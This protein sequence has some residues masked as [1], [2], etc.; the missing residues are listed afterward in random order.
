MDST[1]TLQKNEKVTDKIDDMTDETEDTE[2]DGNSDA[3]IKF[4]GDVMHRAQSLPNT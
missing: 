3:V 2:D 4:I 1:E